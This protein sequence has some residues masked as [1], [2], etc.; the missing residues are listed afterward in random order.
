MNR[1]EEGLSIKIVLIVLFLI[2]V[3]MYYT[4]TPVWH[5]KPVVSDADKSGKTIT[6]TSKKPMVVQQ[7]VKEQTRTSGWG[8]GVGSGAGACG[9]FIPGYSRSKSLVEPIFVIKIYKLD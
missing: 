4:T 6:I 9:E 3:I 8:V 7:Y 1:K 5:D 2:F